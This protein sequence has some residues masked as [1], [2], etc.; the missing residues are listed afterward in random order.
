MFYVKFFKCAFWLD[1]VVVFRHVVSKEDMQVE[2]VKIEVVRGGPYLHQLLRSGVLWDLQAIID[3][4]YR[5]SPLLHLL[6]LDSLDRV[7]F[8][9]FGE[10]E[11]RFQKLKIF[12]T[13]TPILALPQEVVDFI[14]Y[15]DAFRVGLSGVL[16]QKGKVIAYAS[17]K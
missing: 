3:Y 13:S 16:M 6:W 10:C 8:Q 14:M 2:P 7:S 1:Y 11:E 17:K 9:W 15:C 12:L 4:F 5:A